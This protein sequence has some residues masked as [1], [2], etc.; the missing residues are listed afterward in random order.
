M[1]LPDI[2]FAEPSRPEV[3]EED[4][5]ITEDVATDMSAPIIPP[6]PGFSQ[7]SWPREDWQVGGDSSLFT[8]NKELP[9]WSPWSSGGLMVD[10]PLLP[11]SPIILDSSDD[12]VAAQVGSSRDE[13][14]TRSE[15]VVAA[16]SV[17]DAPAEVMDAALLADSPLPTAEGLLQDLMWE[18]VG[19]RPQDRTGH[20]DRPAPSRVPQWRLAREGPFL[21]ERSSSVLRSFGAGCAFRNTTYRASDCAAPS[22][23]LGVPLNHPRFLEWIG[24]PESASLLDMGPGRWLDAL[25]REKAMAAAIQLHRDI[26]L[27]TTNLDIL[28]QYALSLQGTASKMLETSLSCSDFPVADVVA[29][30]LGPRRFGSDGGD[31]PMAALTGSYPSHIRHLSVDYSILD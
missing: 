16:P 26:C 22:D 19:S 28:D 24:V 27:M 29:G 15:A 6:P 18:L 23:E 13:S 20:G 11:L 10:L 7:F 14:S 2:I 5:M 12:S 1:H 25:S 4:V 17:G 8:V 21:A 31:G 3:I 30:A 9:N